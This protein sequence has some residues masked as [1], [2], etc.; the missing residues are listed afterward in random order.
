MNEI[1]KANEILGIYRFYKMDGKLYH[2][3]EDDRLDDLFEAVVNA[4][5]DCGILKPLLP[6]DEFVI[7]CRGLQN[8]ERVWLQR[9]E[10]Q[11]TRAF[12]LSDI[13]DFLRLFVGRT[14]LRVN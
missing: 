6:R 8:K 7:P 10:H 3:D 12:F 5:N 9:F 14:K 4:I 11:D 13:Y 1:D 2:Y